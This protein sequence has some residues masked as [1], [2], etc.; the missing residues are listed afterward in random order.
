MI[1]QSGMGVILNINLRNIYVP[2]KA[3]RQTHRGSEKRNVG[4]GWE[5][6]GAM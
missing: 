3:S 5:Q 6:L 2:A 1:K 4:A